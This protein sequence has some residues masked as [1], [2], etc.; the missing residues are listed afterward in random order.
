MATKQEG[1]EGTGDVLDNLPE[2]KQLVGIALGGVVLGAYAMW[3]T[4]DLLPRA[5][6]FIFVAVGV[7]GMLYGREDGRA[8]LVY[9]G[10][11]FSGLLFLTPV[12]MILPRV[13]SA[14]AYG[15]GVFELVFVTMNLVLFVVFLIPAAIVAYLSYRIS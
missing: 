7:A 4:A 14:G 6:V 8:R 15:R 3:I 10:Y 5:L 12:M 13:L 9:A 2:A 11:V 1:D